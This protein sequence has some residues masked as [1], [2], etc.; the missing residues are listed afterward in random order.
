[1]IEFDP[2]AY[3]FSLNPAEFDKYRAP[4]GASISANQIKKLENFL[5]RLPRDRNMLV[6]FWRFVYCMDIRIIR[7]FAGIEYVNGVIEALRFT[8]KRYL[9][10]EKPISNAAMGKA[11]ELLLPD[12]EIILISVDKGICWHNDKLMDALTIRR[13]IGGE[14]LE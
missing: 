12:Y 2:R 3:L 14:A 11:F 7:R 1:M 8:C 6:Y 9:E 5:C 13:A 10:M 4:Q